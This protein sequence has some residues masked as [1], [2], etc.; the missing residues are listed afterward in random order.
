MG[1]LVLNLKLIMSHQSFKS[2]LSLLSRFFPEGG[3]DVCTQAKFALL[4]MD[5][6]WLSFGAFCRMDF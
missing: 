6:E 5:F 1:G 2:G 3:G 4:H